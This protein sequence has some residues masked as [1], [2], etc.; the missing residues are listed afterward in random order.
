MSIIKYVT[1]D[2]LKVILEKLKAWMPFKKSQ[3]GV[4]TIEG[5]IHMGN[6]VYIMNNDN[7]KEILLQDVLGATVVDPPGAIDKNKIDDII[8]EYN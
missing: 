1:E 3:D 2:S 4:V 5:E 7:D 8:N 6:K